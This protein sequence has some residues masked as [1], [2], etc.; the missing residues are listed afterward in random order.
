MPYD[1]MSECD[2]E[3]LLAAYARGDAAAARALTT[4]LTPRVFGHA[5]RMLGG[6]RA[7]AEDVTQDA[8][9]RLWRAAPDWRSGEAKVTTWLYRVTANLCIDRMRKRRG[10]TDIDQVPE[11]VDDAPSAAQ[12]MQEAARAEALQ[13]ALMDLPERQRQAVILRHI[14]GLSN[15]EIAQIM[16]INVRAVESLTARGK[17][18][19]EAI[20]SGRRDEL[21][22]EDDD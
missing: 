5:Y 1:A 2:D 6:D 12:T 16:D 7:E 8:L 19:L 18:A 11:P 9:L 3:E 20:L 10:S 13:A 15:P 17:R 4:R 14:E 21:G 22:Y